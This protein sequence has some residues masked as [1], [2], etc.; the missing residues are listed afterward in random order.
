ML[1]QRKKKKEKLQAVLQN[2]GERRVKED[3]RY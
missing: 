1:E 3:E 2:L